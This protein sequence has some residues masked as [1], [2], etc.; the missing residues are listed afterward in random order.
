MFRVVATLKVGKN[1]I[2]IPQLWTL[3]KEAGGALYVQYTN[4]NVNDRYAVRVSGGVQVPMLDLY[5]KMDDASAAERQSRAETYIKELETYVAE[6]EKKHQEV[7]K[8]SDN[9]LVKY[10][11]IANDCILGASDIML[12]TM[13]ISLP[14]QQILAGVGTGSTQEKAKKLVTSMEAME[15]MMY[16]FYQHKGLNNNAADVKD[17]VPVN[18]LNIRYQTMFAG[19]FMY[20]SGNHI[21]IEWGSAP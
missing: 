9:K 8:D 14:A 18:H 11:Y 16:L 10:D 13:M 20:A 5:Q 15:N 17:K 4:N 6:I 2:T 3:Q 1:D 12:N 19:A 21:G 7:H